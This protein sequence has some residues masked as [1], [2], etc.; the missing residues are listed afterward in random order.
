M[1]TV[2][3]SVGDSYFTM[4]NSLLA[5]WLRLT[6]GREQAER[7]RASTPVSVLCSCDAAQSTRPSRHCPC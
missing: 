2:R 6:G 5:G 1:H 3:L 4:A 7:R